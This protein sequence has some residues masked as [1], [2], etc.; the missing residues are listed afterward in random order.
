MTADAF[1]VIAAGLFRAILAAGLFAALALVGY[2]LL[3]NGP[4]SRKTELTPFVL[5]PFVPFDASRIS[6]RPLQAGPT[7]EAGE[8]TGAAG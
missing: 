5:T 4:E 2:G 6:A 8:K 7:A 3:P 1:G